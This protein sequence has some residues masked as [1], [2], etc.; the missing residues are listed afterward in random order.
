MDKVL[1]CFIMF[2]FPRAAFGNL[3]IVLYS[4]TSQCNFSFSLAF[5]ILM[6]STSMYLWALLFPNFSCPTFVVKKNKR[7][8]KTKQ[9]KIISLKAKQS[10]PKAQRGNKRHLQI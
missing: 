3:Q 8:L 4:T 1:V 7:T 5:D 2:A 9:M 10:K 6:G